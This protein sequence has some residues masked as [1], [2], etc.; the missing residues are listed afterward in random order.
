MIGVADNLEGGENNKRGWS[1]K[2]WRDKKRRMSDCYEVWSL[3]NRM[4]AME[5]WRCMTV[6]VE[7]MKVG[8]PER[9]SC[10]GYRHGGKSYGYAV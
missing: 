8:N 1:W 6:V 4:I 3:Q 2:S 10:A 9:D 7:D 5:S